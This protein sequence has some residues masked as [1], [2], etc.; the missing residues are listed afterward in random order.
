M[1]PRLVLLPTLLV[2]S[3]MAGGLKDVKH[4]VMMMQENR[5]FDHVSS[6]P[7]NN[8]IRAARILLLPQYYGTMAGVRGFGDPNVQINPDGRNTFQQ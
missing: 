5:A 7:V 8:I 3:A 6:F 1:L 2:A 4:V